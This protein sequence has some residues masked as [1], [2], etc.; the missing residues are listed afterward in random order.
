MQI[1]DPKMDSGYIPPGD[2][3]EPDFDVC[4]AL[5]V[6]QVLG[7][8][9][10]LLRLEL[11]FHD[12]Y[13]LS[14]TIFTSLHVFRL[15]SPEN[16]YPYL[17]GDGVVPPRKSSRVPE[18]AVVLDALRAYCLGVIVCCGCILKLIQSQTYYE[19]CTTPVANNLA[20][21]TYHPWRSKFDG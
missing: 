15:I 21:T 14:Q 17:F 1:M 10:E 5:P 8:M 6:E 20:G 11:L 2:T 7:I 9:D 3:F 12:G 13:P 4:A 19:V 16:D 18:E